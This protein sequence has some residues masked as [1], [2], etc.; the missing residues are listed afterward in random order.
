MARSAVTAQS[1]Q[2]AIDD[3]EVRQSL[4][5]RDARSGTRLLAAMGRGERVVNVENLK[6]ARRHGR[7]NLME[8]G[9]G[10][11]RRIG[12]ARRIFRTT[13][14]RFRGQGCP[15]VGQRPTA[16]F[17]SGSR[18]SRSR[19]IASLCPQ[20]IAEAR[21]FTISSTACRMRSASRRIRHRIAECVRLGELRVGTST[22]EP[23]CRRLAAS[24]TRA[25]RHPSWKGEIAVGSYFPKCLRQRNLEP[26]KAIGSRSSPQAK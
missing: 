14:V 15:A 9:R 10:E 21:A 25:A 26:L 17:M 22:Y 24:G 5:R 2:D 20:A 4:A 7:A 6:L 13:D 1:G 23:L 3:S 19:C 16:T 11:P 12:F 8:Q 18:R